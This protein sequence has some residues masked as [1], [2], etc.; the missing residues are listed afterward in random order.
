MSEPAHTRW[1]DE[2]LALL[3]TLGGRMSEI[4]HGE[5]LD[6]PDVNRRDELGILA[7]M[8][9]RLARELRVRRRQTIE[10]QRELERRVTELS[11]AYETQER[12]LGALRSLPAPI[13]DLY[14]GL[15]VVPIAGPVDPARVAYL[16]PAL[17]ERLVSRRPEVVIFHLAVPQ[18]L[19]QEVAAVLFRAGQSLHKVGA[20]AL[21]SGA[22]APHPPGLASLTPCDSLQEAWLSAL[23]LIGYR[24]TR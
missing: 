5:D 17:R 1:S 19:D 9:S 8:V 6:V 23:D 2:D 20:R 7:N 16:L 21:I 13:L 11:S 18:Q 12:L 24:I 4:I 3:R 15:V 10:H 14:E 22:L